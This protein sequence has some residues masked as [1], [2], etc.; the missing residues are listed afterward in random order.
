MKFS[1][2]SILAAACLAFQVQAGEEQN[3][4][5]RG[6]YSSDFDSVQVLNETTDTLS[7]NV[8]VAPLDLSQIEV[9]ERH[10]AKPLGSKAWTLTD[11]E[12]KGLQTMYTKAYRAQFD[13]VDTLQLVDDE[14]SADIVVKTVVERI[15]PLAPKDE[16]GSR[17][18]WTYYFSNGSGSM[19]VRFYI[20]TKDGTHY[21]IS[22]RDDVGS[23]WQRNNRHTNMMNINRL[24]TRW[25]SDIKH[26][27]S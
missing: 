10:S 27:L 25:A 22:D 20:S 12:K 16:M 15:Y 14:A 21:D 4:V 11:E 17:D 8:Y 3:A 9:I 2:Y 26:L 23:L 18:P 1:I 19:T 13:S 7:G 24:F 6:V 5:W